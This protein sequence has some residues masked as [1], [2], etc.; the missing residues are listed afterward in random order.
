[1]HLQSHLSLACNRISKLAQ[2]RPPSAS[3]SSLNFCLQLH[4]QPGSIT[5]SRCISKLAQTRPPSASPNWLYHSPQVYLW[6]HSSSGSKYISKLSGPRPWSVSLSSLDS[7]VQ[8]NLSTRSI[9]ASKYIDTDRRWVYGETG[10]TEVGWPTGSTYSVDPGVDRHPLICISSGSTR[11]HGFSRP[12][13]I[14]SSHFPPRHLELE[15]PIMLDYH[16]WPDW[17][18]IYREILE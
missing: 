11:L 2:S 10:E 9:T 18:Y 3:R 15:P 5:A 16:L 6:V 1:V 8:V 12:G 13:C 4:L 7:C 14:I 17:P